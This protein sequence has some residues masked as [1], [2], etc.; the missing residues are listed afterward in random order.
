MT[1]Y[2]FNILLIYL[3]KINYN[4]III[5]ILNFILKLYMYFIIFFIIFF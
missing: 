1:L 4:I 5:K 2:I 3:I